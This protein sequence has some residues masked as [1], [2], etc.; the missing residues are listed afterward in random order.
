M[1]GC[2]HRS[3]PN[4]FQWQVVRVWGTREEQHLVGCIDSREVSFVLNSTS[5]AKIWCPTRQILLELGSEANYPI[6]EISADSVRVPMLLD[7]DSS[8]PVDDVST[9]LRTLPAKRNRYMD[10]FRSPGAGD[11]L[12]RPCLIADSG[13][14]QSQSR[15]E[16]VE[17]SG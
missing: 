16:F 6:T 1:Y 9:L 8:T 15:L 2:W 17:R 5:E 7:A 11:L 3:E 10:G 13:R 4:T 12:S 14:E